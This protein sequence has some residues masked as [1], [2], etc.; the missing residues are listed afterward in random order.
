MLKRV[1]RLQNRHGIGPYRHYGDYNT[2]WAGK[3][4]TQQHRPTPE[5]D[6]NL[7]IEDWEV[8]AFTTYKGLCR[9]F[10]ARDR[11]KLSRLG[12][13]VV[14]ALVDDSQIKRG[15]YQCVVPGDT[16]WYPI[17]VEKNV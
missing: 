13:R 14:S 3:R 5:L 12:F 6:G 15:R 10:T 11:Q 16:K 7:I 4:H 1:Y 17:I 9:W 2:A 8:C